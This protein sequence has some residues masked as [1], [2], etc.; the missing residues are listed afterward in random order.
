MAGRKGKACAAHA[1]C[2]YQAATR[3]RARAPRAHAHAAVV[4]VRLVQTAQL[5]VLRSG[6]RPLHARAAAPAAA[7]VTPA[8]RAA[9]RA[10]AAAAAAQPAAQRLQRRGSRLHGARLAN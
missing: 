3:A 9:Q 2:L 10:A 6:V 8:A 5:V 4:A 7:G 1:R